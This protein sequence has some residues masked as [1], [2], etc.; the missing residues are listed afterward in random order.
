MAVAITAYDRVRLTSYFDHRDPAKLAMA[1]LDWYRENGIEIHVGD[2]AAQIDRARK[3]VVSEKGWEVPYDRVVLATGSRPF[4]PPIPGVN[5]RGVFV[6]R[7]I[8]DLDAIIEYAKDARSC[9]VIGGGLLG[10]EA[11]KAAFDLGLQTHVVE[12]APRLMP[13]QIDDAGSQLLVRKIEDLGVQVHLQ[14]ATQNFLGNGKVDGMEFSDGA[15]L[16]V[17]MV[18]V[19]AGIRPRDE[20][21]RAC[22][23]E[24]GHRG[25]ISVNDRLQTSDSDIYAIGE[26]ALH[27]GMVY[28]LIAPGWDMAE[29]AAA[30]LVG[31]DVSFTG[32]DM[33]TK[34][35]LMG[36]DVAS[37][38]NY[39]PVRGSSSADRGRSLCRRLQETA[40]LARR[41]E[42]GR[43]HARWRCLGL[44]HAL[45][46][47]QDGREPDGRALATG[48]RRQCWHARRL[49]LDE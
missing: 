19:S 16:E 40:V 46:A 18:I 22:G 28:G 11:A 29:V 26:A 38:G 43:R 14:R 5:K 2:R 24:V 23:L 47:R 3:V 49:G 44:S 27:R 25:G 21:A 48:R 8:E 41:A 10:L 6:Y 13:R 34:L 20:L 7:T 33:S 39:G 4:V 1:R 37:F 36:V 15:R 42:A 17:D 32:A 45:R 12:F 30:R 35:K 9:A 31:R